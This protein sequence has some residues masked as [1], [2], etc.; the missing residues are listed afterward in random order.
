MEL[1][2]IK[3]LIFIVYIIMMHL[4]FNYFTSCQNA[5]RWTLIRLY[6]LL[7]WTILSSEYSMYI[8]DIGYVGRAPLACLPNPILKF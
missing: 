7:F 3:A 5:G 6:Y 8:I 2:E 1:E 4:L